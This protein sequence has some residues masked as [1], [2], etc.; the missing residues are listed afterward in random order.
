L[1]SISGEKPIGILH[2]DVFV[3]LD[4]INMIGLEA[5]QRF[6]DLARGGDFR[7]SVELSHQERF[8][9]VPIAQR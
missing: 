3:I 6:I 9:P 5:A 4:Q 8:A 1:A 7:A 2:P